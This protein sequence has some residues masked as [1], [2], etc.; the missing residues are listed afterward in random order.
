MNKIIIPL[1]ILCVITFGFPAEG[2]AKANFATPALEK[3]FNIGAGELD[4]DEMLELLFDRIS[5]EPYNYENYGMLA[6][7]YDIAGDYAN[8]LE[9]LKQQVAYLPEDIESKDVYFGNLARAYMLN[10]QWE[11]GKEWL[12][13]ADALNKENVYNRW[14]SFDYHMQ[15]SKDYA[16]AAQELQWL[17]R[18]YDPGDDVFGEAFQKCQANQIQPDSI[19]TLFKE[20]VALVPDNAKAFRVLGVA[21]RNLSEINFRQNMPNAVEIMEKAQA[22]DPSYIPT[23]ISLADTYVMASHYL[24]DHTALDRALEWLEKGLAQ[25]PSHLG[26]SFMMGNIYIYMLKYDDAIEKLEFAYQNGLDNEQLKHYLAIA[27]NGKAYGFYES[28]TGLEEG[29]DLIDKALA[30]EPE[31]G[32]F[33]S[34][35]AELLYKQG[36]YVEAYDY[37]QKSA[38]LV[39]DHPE[40]QADVVM[41]EQALAEH[42]EIELEEGSQK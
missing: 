22:M 32:I 40:I 30:F 35:K 23:Y 11:E 2:R 26:V 1:T 39:P 3:L 6:F 19:L 28:G 8:E 38:A 17:D 18:F 9:A 34:T 21:T 5:Q 31:N 7:V 15:F 27:Y 24:N 16:A 36:K 10:G 20:A 12:A 33:L 41:I 42:K 14:N 25:D 37:I 29:I 4:H 13:R